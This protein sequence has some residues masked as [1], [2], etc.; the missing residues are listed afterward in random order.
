M[1]TLVDPCILRS[2]RNFSPYIMPRTPPW[3]VASPDYTTMSPSSC[4]ASPIY[5]P[6]MSP[7][8][9]DAESHTSTRCSWRTRGAAG[10]AA[11]SDGAYTPRRTW[12]SSVQRLLWCSRQWNWT[13][14]ILFHR[15]R[16]LEL[17]GLAHREFLI[18]LKDTFMNGGWQL[19]SPI[20]LV[21]VERSLL[22]RWVALYALAS[23]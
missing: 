1:S 4:A 3:R 21:E 22:I 9:S 15:L 17:L 2:S 7:M 8:F 18:N 20:L 16:L 11:T 13:N 6:N 19:F 14:V 12:H 5:T 10:S 23:V